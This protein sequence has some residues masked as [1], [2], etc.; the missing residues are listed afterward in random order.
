LQNGPCDSLELDYRGV[1]GQ[2]GLS[3]PLV[4]G[5]VCVAL[6]DF[7]LELIGAG[8]R[9]IYL[10]LYLLRVPDCGL[11]ANEAQASNHW[12]RVRLT[13]RTCGRGRGPVTC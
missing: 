11:Y 12:F 1:F 10:A 3:F 9:W 4:A 8:G 2:L 5:W 13:F 6:V 7:V